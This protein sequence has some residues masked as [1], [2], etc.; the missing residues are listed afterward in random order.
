MLLTYSLL[1]VAI[2]AVWLPQ[3]KLRGRSLPPWLVV[4]AFAIAAALAARIIEP[5]AIG[6]LLLFTGCAIQSTRSNGATASALTIVAAL[7]ALAL[8]LHVVPGFHNPTLFV[9]EK[10]SADGVPFTQYLNFD[11]GAAGLVIL[12]V[13]V[14]RGAGAARLGAVFAAVLLTP[15][16]VFAMATATGYVHVDPKWPAT[17]ITFLAANLM[18]TVVAEEAFFRGF[19]QARAEA[20]ASRVGDSGVVA[21]SRAG[22]RALPARYFCVVALSGVLFGIAHIGGGAALMATATVAGIGYA[23]AFAESGR[24]EVAILVHFM[25]NALHFLG[26]TYPAV[27]R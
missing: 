26:F 9:N 20:F 27:A 19:L 25:V 24:I 23:V 14:R 5:L 8:S 4:F 10:I 11:K 6:A 3:L 2:G 22:V 12:A 21:K 7:F 17:A 13:Y 15:A 16:A 1:G 18:F